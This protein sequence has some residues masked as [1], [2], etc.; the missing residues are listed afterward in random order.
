VGSVLHGAGILA[1]YILGR[2]LNVE[3]GGADVGVSHQLLEGGQ[4]DSGP[5]HISSKSVSKPVGIGTEDVTTQAVM[6]E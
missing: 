1:P 2:E 5:N 4:R 6:A 3:H